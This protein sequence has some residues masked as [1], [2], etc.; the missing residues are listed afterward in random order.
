M[1]EQK[2][3]SFRCVKTNT[4]NE[5][6]ALPD[7]LLSRRRPPQK[8]GGDQPCHTEQKGSRTHRATVKDFEKVAGPASEA[9]CACNT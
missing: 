2:G 6:Q 4:L 7:N 1:T 8:E 3:N 5:W 9:T